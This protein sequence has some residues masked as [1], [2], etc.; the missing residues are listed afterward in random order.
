MVERK[1][2]E[3]EVLREI[4]YSSDES[5]TTEE[6]KEGKRSKSSID[7]DAVLSIMESIHDI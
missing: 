7:A 4:D 3:V 6:T 1:R 2:I 5:P